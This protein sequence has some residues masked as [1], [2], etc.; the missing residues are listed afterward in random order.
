MSAISFV[1]MARSIDSGSPSGNN[2]D[3]EDSDNG[4]MSSGGL[5][6]SDSTP[7]LESEEHLNPDRDPDEPWWVPMLEEE[8]AYAHQQQPPAFTYLVL[9][10]DEYVR[11]RILNSVNAHARRPFRLVTTPNNVDH[12]IRHVAQ[13]AE[14]WPVED[15]EISPTQRIV[16]IDTSLVTFA[17]R[18][19]REVWVAWAVDIEDGQEVFMA[20][21]HSEHQPLVIETPAHLPRANTRPFRQMAHQ[22]GPEVPRTPNDPSPEPADPRVP[23][24]S[25]P[26]PADPRVPVPH[27]P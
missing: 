17:D 23:V 7:S 5:V 9:D 24:P 2:D 4:S 1:H 8:I 22:D 26:E 12:M 11:W 21:A 15:E 13:D 19:I 16:R 20:V 14:Q 6:S 3:S 10:E 27:S 18:I 25:S